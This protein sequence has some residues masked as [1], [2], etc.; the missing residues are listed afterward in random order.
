MSKKV[1]VYGIDGGTVSYIGPLLEKGGMPILRTLA[2]GG[3]SGDM[4][5]SPPPVTAAAWS[6]IITGKTPVASPHGRV[7]A[8]AF[9]EELLAANPV[10]ITRSDQ[11][12]TGT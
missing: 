7:L 6:N 10:R 2:D 9:E 1:L 5:S 12:T 8:E 11:S 3:V 4:I